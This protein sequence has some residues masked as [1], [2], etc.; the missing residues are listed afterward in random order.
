MESHIGVS[1]M[2]LTSDYDFPK[3]SPTREITMI[4]LVGMLCRYFHV[5]PTRIQ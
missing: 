1:V 4:L 3:G 5:C 2:F